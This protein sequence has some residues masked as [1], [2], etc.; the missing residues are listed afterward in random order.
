MEDHT[1]WRLRPSAVP[2]ATGRKADSKIAIVGM[3][4]R[5]PGAADHNL[6]WELLE[7]G[8]DVHREVNIDPLLRSEICL[9]FLGAQ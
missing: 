4:G 5:F 2:P 3:A 1:T 8:L 7:K 6:L 9:T